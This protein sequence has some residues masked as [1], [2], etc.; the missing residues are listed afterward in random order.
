M[1]NFT[2]SVLG[3][4]I[5]S[6]GVGSCSKKNTPGPV[7]DYYTFSGLHGKWALS[8]F[9]DPKGSQLELDTLIFADNFTY[10]L[11]RVSDTVDK[12]F[13]KVGYG[14]RVNGFG[15]KQAYDSIAL[16][17]AYLTQAAIY[18]KVLYYRQTTLDTLSIS[19]WY[20]DSASSQSVAFYTR[21]DQ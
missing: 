2:L 7:V 21:I 6:I 10:A 13:F 4:V 16:N 3:F 5:I 12:G 19:T 18:P 8:H 9:T 14:I 1:R 17:T 20:R 11:I 15:H